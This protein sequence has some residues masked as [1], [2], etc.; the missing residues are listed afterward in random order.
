[1]AH[2]SSKRPPELG[3]QVRVATLIAAVTLGLAAGGGGPVALAPEQLLL[4]LGSRQLRERD[5][6]GGGGPGRT[7]REGGARTGVILHERRA[8]RH[9]HLPRH[10]GGLRCRT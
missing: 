4:P 8:V 6:A 1:M 7:G 3:A 2:Q 9:G 10:P 5:P